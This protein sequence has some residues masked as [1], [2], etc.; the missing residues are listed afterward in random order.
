MF[1]EKVASLCCKRPIS[2]STCTQ[3]KLANIEFDVGAKKHR[4][5]FGKDDATTD[6]PHAL[7]ITSLGDVFRLEVLG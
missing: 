7:L 5:T 3:D 4:V 6:D 2:I 1:H